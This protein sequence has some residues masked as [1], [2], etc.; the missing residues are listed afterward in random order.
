MVHLS[1]HT[2]DKSDDYGTV[3][4]TEGNRREYVESCSALRA[5]QRQEER[6]KK[7]AQTLKS[8]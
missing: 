2:N 8:R 6:P 5:V 7:R 4:Y 1:L 3:F